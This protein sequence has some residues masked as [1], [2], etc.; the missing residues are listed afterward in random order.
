MR[1]QLKDNDRV[2]VKEVRVTTE[3]SGEAIALIK[4]PENVD[5]S[6]APIFCE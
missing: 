3:V 6:R 5:N 1:A 4:T 2:G